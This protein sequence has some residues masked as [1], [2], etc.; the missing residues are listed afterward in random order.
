MQQLSHFRRRKIVFSIPHPSISS[1]LSEAT[2]LANAQQLFDFKSLKEALSAQPVLKKRV[3]KKRKKLK[4]PAADVSSE[5]KVKSLAVKKQYLKLLQ[6]LEQKE[7]RGLSGD[8][9]KKRLKKDSLQCFRPYQ[10]LEQIIRTTKAK[11]K[12]VERIK[13]SHNNIP[14]R[15]L[16]KSIVSEES[17]KRMVTYAEF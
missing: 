10:D 8:K 2:K 16:K 17:I 3:L 4:R 11:A 7:K 15:M 14:N 13:N 12:Q 9:K 5:K 1:I 6:A